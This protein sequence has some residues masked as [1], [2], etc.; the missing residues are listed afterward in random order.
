MSIPNERKSM[1]SEALV[2]KLR[3]I[4]DKTEPKTKQRT[5]DT[6]IIYV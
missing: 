6:S 2:N 3:S 1:E 4:T 5:T